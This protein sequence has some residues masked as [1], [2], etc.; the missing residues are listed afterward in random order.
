MIR[1]ALLLLGFLAA[2]AGSLS[3]QSGVPGGDPR[4]GDRMRAEFYAHVL[5]RTDTLMRRW[6]AAWRSDDAAAAAGLYA[7]NAVLVLPDGRLVVGRDMIGRSLEEGLPRMGEIQAG[8]RDFDAS[9]RMAYMAGPARFET[10]GMI[11]ARSAS[12]GSHATVAIRTDDGWRIRLQLFQLRPGAE[13]LPLSAPGRGVVTP[14]RP[15]AVIDG[16]GPA[17]PYYERTF[18]AVTRAVGDLSVAWQDGDLH[19]ARSLYG[20]DALLHSPL[21]GEDYVGASAV[22]G[23]L[24]GLVSRGGQ[25]HMAVLDFDASGRMAVVYGRYLVER[26]RGADRE[27]LT[28]PYVLVYRLERDEPRIRAHLMGRDPR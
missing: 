27:N 7:E 13:S 14:D 15:D 28:G 16:R 22:A 8:R 2:P 26:A 5:A 6:S 21:D 9:E 19:R 17:R 10:G 23:H 25:V 24:P 20:P 3:A 12:R 1:S 18:A 4:D 11:S